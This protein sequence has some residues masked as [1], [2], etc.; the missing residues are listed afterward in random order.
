MGRYALPRA[1]TAVPIVVCSYYLP[2]DMPHDSD[3]PAFVSTSTSD[4]DTAIAERENS[5]LSQF[6]S[7][8]AVM[9]CLVTR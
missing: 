8:F 5:V 1:V 6:E 4:L 7:C 9:L 3:R 2:T